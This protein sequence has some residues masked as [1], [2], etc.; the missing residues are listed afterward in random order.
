MSLV[1][2]AQYT[3]RVAYTPP[4]PGSPRPVYSKRSVVLLTSKRIDQ[5]S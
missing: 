1:P 5:L 3:E 4:L 2:R